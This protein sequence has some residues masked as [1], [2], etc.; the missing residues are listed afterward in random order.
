MNTKAAV[1]ASTVV[2]GIIGFVLLAG[3]KPEIIALLL[4]GALFL[5]LLCASVTVLICL[6][7]GIY[8]ACGGELP[9]WFEKYKNYMPL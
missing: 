3:W 8:E 6:W 2:A 9:K 1:Y 4:F 7:F 5:V